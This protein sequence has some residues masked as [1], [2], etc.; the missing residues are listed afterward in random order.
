MFSQ[1]VVLRMEQKCSLAGS[2]GHQEDGPVWIW[3]KSGL[4]SGS[5]ENKDGALEKDKRYN[6]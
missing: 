4:G 1:V 6:D 5:W 2:R 3:L